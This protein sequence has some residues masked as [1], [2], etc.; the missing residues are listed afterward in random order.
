M[1][2]YFYAGALIV[3]AGV[4]GAG[5]AVGH[6]LVDARRADRFVTVKGV[7]ER[8]VEADLAF[9]SITLTAPAEELRSAQADIDR[10]VAQVISYL[11]EF[12]LDSSAVSREGSQVV[13]R[14]TQVQLSGDEPL[15]FVVNQTLLVRSTDVEAI[16]A[17]S[18][19]VGRLLAAGVPITSGNSWEYTRPTYTFTRLNDVKPEMIA[20]AT[21]SAREA[22]QQ[23]A[24]D[25]GDRIGGIRRANQGVFVIQARDQAPGVIESAQRLKT[26]RVVTTVEYYLLD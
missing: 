5:V 13:D 9:W 8:E 1:S 4:T 26:V 11:A 7:S 18:Q 21:A 15:R 12:G 22:A 23:F 2:S 3:A 24:N 10:S 14:A 6:G 17:A 16:H 19:S 25:S 20:E